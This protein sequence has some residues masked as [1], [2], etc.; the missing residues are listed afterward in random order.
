VR[1]ISYCIGDKQRRLFTSLL[2]PERYPAVD[3]IELYGMRWEVELGYG[4]LKQ[5]LLQGTP[6]LRSRK[7]DGV[8][9][10][11]WGIFIAFNL[12][13]LQMLRVAKKAGVAANRV[14]FRHSIHL[15]RIFCVVHIWATAPSKI[16][17]RL[18][19]LTEMLSLLLLP[20]KRRGR[21]FPRALK[22]P[23]SPYPN[24]KK[25]AKER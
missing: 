18:D 25:A 17:T 7:A 8:H 9:Q 16:P 23:K 13:R 15:V 22:R 5:D 12:V 24:K 6:V 14:S 2:D 4:E 3:I 1:A 21:S 10:E 11:V 19:E 20:P